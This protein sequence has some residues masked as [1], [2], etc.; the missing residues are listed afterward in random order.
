MQSTIRVEGTG[1][2]RGQSRHQISA[3]QFKIYFNKGPA[4]GGEGGQ[5]M[6]T[7]VLYT[8]VLYAT[9]WN[10]AVLAVMGEKKLAFLS[11]F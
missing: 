1:G 11:N 6:V 9:F 3:Y 10:M 5:I 7:P 4:G 8:V 2:A